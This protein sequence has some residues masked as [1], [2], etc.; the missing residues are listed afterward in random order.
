MLRVEVTLLIFIAIHGGKD[1]SRNKCKKSRQVLSLA[2]ALQVVGIT[3]SGVIIQKE[4]GGGGGSKK[5]RK[6][7]DPYTA[8]NT[9]KKKKIEDE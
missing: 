5:Q 9:M 3:A 4:E 8:V 1:N 2:T 6:T 7:N